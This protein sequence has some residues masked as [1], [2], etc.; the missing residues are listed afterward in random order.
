MHF[1]PDLEPC[2]QSLSADSDEPT[3][4]EYEFV[5][6]RINIRKTL[7]LLWW[8]LFA[9]GDL[10]DQE[11]D[12][13]GETGTVLVEDFLEE[14]TEPRDMGYHPQGP[15]NLNHRQRRCPY[16]DP[17][18]RLVLTK[19]TSTGAV[20]RLNKLDISD[21]YVLQHGAGPETLIPPD[22]LDCPDYYVAV[23]PTSG[24]RQENGHLVTETPLLPHFSVFQDLYESHPFTVGSLK[25]GPRTR[26]TPS[27][28]SLLQSL[29][30]R[31][32]DLVE[33][34]WKARCSQP[35]APAPLK[36]FF[37]GCSSISHRAHSHKEGIILAAR[38]IVI[39]VDLSVDQLQGPT[40][41]AALTLHA[42]INRMV[43][44]SLYFITWLTNYELA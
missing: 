21:V 35:C 8:D 42:E 14:F 19:R 23:N 34:R 27:S 22:S 5:M 33:E 12:E 3:L 32:S 2:A 18:I 44:L 20:S 30:P 1:M 11:A 10:T 31:V 15:Q 41:P 7:V 25:D 16:F 17:E 6:I 24:S 29:E 36:T 28:I 4:R 13:L 37:C 39:D 9:D 26:L 43:H 40:D 38:D